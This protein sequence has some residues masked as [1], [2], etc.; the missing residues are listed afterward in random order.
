MS[1]HVTTAV[2]VGI[3]QWKMIDVV[4]YKTIPLREVKGLLKTNVH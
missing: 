1:G 3:V 4:E 2:V